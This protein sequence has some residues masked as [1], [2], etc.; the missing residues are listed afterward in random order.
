MMKVITVIV[1]VIIA[2]A[3]VMIYVFCY[4]PL[5]P[6]SPFHPGFNALTF[7]KYR[8]IYP[9]D[10][11]IAPAYL[12]L[13]SLL[14]AAEDFHR[15]QYKKP[16][17]IVISATALQHKRFSMSGGHANT[18]QT[19][20]VIYVNPSINNALY[21]PEIRLRKSDL[22]FT[23]TKGNI[24]RDLRSFLKHE[25]S[26]ALLYQN[27]TLAKARRVKSWLEEGLAVYF[28]NPHHYY[29]GEELRKLAIGR[30]YFFDLFDDQKD[31]YFVPPEIK[32]YFKYGIY[33]AF[34]EYLIDTNGISTVIDFTHEY[35]VAPQE[36]RG[37]FQSH[38]RTTMDSALLDF[39][40]SLENHQ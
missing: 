38:F 27:T 40:K 15:L 31:A 8:I 21:P 13:D 1:V 22:F 7:D 34:M 24:K 29:H 20:T 39:R 9:L 14:S 12:G 23:Q 3:L 17:T 4:G 25:L 5:F 2:L 11:A 37:L 6:Y 19:G 18:I 33:G 30:D 26:H 35:I 16:I 28:G 10:Y 36:E 32:Y